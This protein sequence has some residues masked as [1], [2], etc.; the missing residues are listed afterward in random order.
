[1]TETD[2]IVVETAE[3]IFADLAGAQTINKSTDGKWKVALW[4]ALAES[5]LPLSWVPEDC[6]GSGASMAEG[7]A[8]IGA[9]GRAGLSV[10]LAETMLAGWWLSQAKIASPEG[11]MTV[12]P[13]NPKDSLTLNA[14]GT[15][16]GR[17]RSVPFASQVQHI[18]VIASGTGGASIA[19]LE[20]GACRIEQGLNLANDPSDIVTFDRVRPLSIAAAPAGIDARSLQLMGAL[21]R[22]L[23]I[24]GAMES[25]LDISVTYAGERVA[26]EKK[27][28]KFQAVQHNLARLAGETSAALAA[29]SSAA[30]ALSHDGA[31][32]DDAILLEV[33]A[34][35]IRCGEAAEKGA[36]I[37]HQVFGAIGFTQEH[38]LHR[39]TLRALA[40]RDDFG[41][42]SFWAVE[43]GRMV[44]ARGADEL[45]PL[46]ASR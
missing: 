33:A 16:S 24:S 28:S 15:I 40:W 32:F 31:A 23:Q 37:A 27:I 35:K 11:M 45:W 17:A 34:A 2:N 46:V 20:A 3:R 12:A 6:D 43:L 36:A 7:F 18:A 30:E 42:E 21:L 22:S 39:F 8:V 25:M 41:S 9:A 1:M 19:L 5:G 14:D 29:A 44:A 13:T 4:Q 10:P 38:I 26:F